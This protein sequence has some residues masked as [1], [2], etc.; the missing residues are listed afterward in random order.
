M[1]T[2]VGG[3]TEQQA[4]ATL[5]NMTADITPITLTEYQQRISKAQQL[6]RQNGLSAVYLNAGT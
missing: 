1:T 6:M 2:G 3:S 5:S 4:L